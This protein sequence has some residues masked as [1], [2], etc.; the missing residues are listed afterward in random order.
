MTRA[1]R[2]PPTVHLA[3]QYICRNF[4]RIECV[5]LVRSIKSIHELL[6][7]AYA[8]SLTLVHY[9]YDVKPGSECNEAECTA[10]NSQDVTG[11]ARCRIIQRLKSTKPQAGLDQDMT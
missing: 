10:L 3:L 4:F 1:S 6:P 2:S 7:V 9:E 5:V 11:P 8:D